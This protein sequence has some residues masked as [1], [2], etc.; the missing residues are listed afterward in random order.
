MVLELDY[1][2][3]IPNVQRKEAIGMNA[4][5]LR[6]KMAECGMNQSQLAVKIGISDNSLSRKILGKREFRLSEVVGICAVLNIENP[7]EIFF[8]ENIPNTQRINYSDEKNT[9][10]G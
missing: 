3:I 6:G 8:D 1:H 2:L 4:N 9:K 7:K 5:L 10:A